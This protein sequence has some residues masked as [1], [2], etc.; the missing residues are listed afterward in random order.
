[1]KNNKVSLVDGKKKKTSNRRSGWSLLL[2]VQES[3]LQVGALRKDGVVNIKAHWLRGTLG[4][5]LS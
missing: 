2:A 3:M 4:Q 5:G 1:M